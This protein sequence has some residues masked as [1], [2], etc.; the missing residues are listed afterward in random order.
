[1]PRRTPLSRWIPWRPDKGDIS[2]TW[3][4]LPKKKMSPPSPME[5]QQWRNLCSMKSFI[6]SA[7]KGFH[8][9]TQRNQFSYQNRWWVFGWIYLAISKLRTG[10][11]KHCGIM[12]FVFRNIRGS[13]RK[14]SPLCA[15]L[16]RF[17]PRKSP[18]SAQTSQNQHRRRMLEYPKQCV[19]KC[20]CT[21]IFLC[22]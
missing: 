22:L 21:L 4:L 9:L 18:S 1:M 10:K 2:T 14:K 7:W 8:P 3:L 15:F 13:L 16:Q 19:G 17:L 11:M 5:N 12:E 6:M 20:G